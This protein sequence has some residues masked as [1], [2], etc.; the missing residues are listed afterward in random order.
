MIRVAR[1]SRTKVKDFGPITLADLNKAFEDITGERP[2]EESAIM[3]HRLPGLGRIEADSNDRMF[4]DSYILNGL[5]AEDIISSVQN[6]D[7]AVYEEKWIN[8][9]NSEG[10]N[11]LSNYIEYDEDR[12]KA[13]LNA[14][15]VCNRKS[16]S[17]FIADIIA[18]I[19]KTS[20]YQV[21]DFK[22]IKISDIIIYSFDFSNKTI[23]NLNMQ[24][25]LMDN[26]DITNVHLNN[27]A[28]L[29]CEIDKIRG[30]SSNKSLPDA[31]ISCKIKEY[32]PV[33]TVNRIKRANLSRA[34][35]ILV[36]II[37]K[38]FSTVTKGNGRREEALLRGLGDKSDSKICDRILNKMLTD[39]LITKHKGRDCWIYSPVL[40][41]T[42]R[43]V[44]ILS[45][46]SNSQDELWLYA[47][48]LD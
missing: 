11:I 48:T 44:K 13:F 2:N 3:L 37:K 17:M 25:V 20:L 40:K 14:A 6:M 5:R 1:I 33:S 35:T 18:A 31:F 4:V 24:N 32:Q 28:I 38:I 39:N 45:D 27:V 19:S 23:E 41:C 16:N 46:L 12:L 30:I 34:E 47:S 8:S 10:V 42:S 21:I 26:L 43:M 9:L 15:V 36:T 22:G 29:N 7:Q